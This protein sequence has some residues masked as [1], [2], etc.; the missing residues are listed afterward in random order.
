M[1]I[2]TASRMGI[3]STCAMYMRDQ[4]SGFPGNGAP[5]RDKVIGPPITGIDSPTP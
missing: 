2:S 1:V 3:S 4:S 5:N